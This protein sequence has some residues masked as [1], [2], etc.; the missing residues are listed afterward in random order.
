[1]NLKSYKATAEHLAAIMWAYAG[2]PLSELPEVARAVVEQGGNPATLRNRL[3]CLKAACRWAW[4]RHG[5]T[6]HDPTTRMQ[7]PSVRNERHV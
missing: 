7:M 5:L 3:S 1:M 2:K 6:E 4:K